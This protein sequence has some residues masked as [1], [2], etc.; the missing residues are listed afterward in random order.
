MGVPFPLLN[1]YL[2]KWLQVSFG[3]TLEES[4]VYSTVYF[5]HRVVGS[6][7]LETQYLF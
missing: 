5:F 3:G 7:L 6:F 4:S 1:F 2:H